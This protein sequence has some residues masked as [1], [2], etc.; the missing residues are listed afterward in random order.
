[1]QAPDQCSLPSDAVKKSIELPFITDDN[2][3]LLSI[4]M[5]NEAIL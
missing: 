1:M 4:R 3:E 2:D 5:A